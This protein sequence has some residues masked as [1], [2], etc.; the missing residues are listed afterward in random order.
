M[1]GLTMA[2]GQSN[3]AIGILR[4]GMVGLAMQATGTVG[5]VGKLAQGLLM[6]GGGSGLV[7]GVAA[8]IGA[9]AL[10]YNALTRD[11]REAKEANDEFMLSLAKI[12]PHARAVIE[13]NKLTTLQEDL[14]KLER[15]VAAR[16]PG[17]RVENAGFQDALRLKNLRTE[18]AGQVALVAQREREAR[19][20]MDRQLGVINRIR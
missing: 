20:E 6:F 9:I 12:G 8:G 13:R 7:L 3:R 17:L 10:A 1:G 16:S 19:L 4:N 5:P 2:S 11:A 15:D 14:V 18:I